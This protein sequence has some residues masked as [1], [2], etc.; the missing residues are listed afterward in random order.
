MERQEA[1]C[2]DVDGVGERLRRDAAHC[3]KP[4]GTPCSPSFIARIFQGSS[5]STSSTVFA[6][7]GKHAEIGIKLQGCGSWIA[8]RKNCTEF[9]Q[10]GFSY[11]HRLIFKRVRPFL[12]CGERSLNFALSCS[13]KRD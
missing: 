6:G 7:N 1:L 5:A 9:S 2:S 8:Y 11:A 12:L 10:L 13:L 3:T 4:V